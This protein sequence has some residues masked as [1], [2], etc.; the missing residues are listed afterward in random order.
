MKLRGFGLMAWVAVLGLLG[1]CAS[2]APRVAA[3]APQDAQ[4]DAA[5]QQFQQAV[6]G[7]E[8]GDAASDKAMHAALDQMRTLASHCA[9]T[10]GCDAGRILLAYDGALR[11]LANSAAVDE[12]PAGD[13]L[14]SDNGAGTATGVLTAVPQTQ[15]TV[16]LLKNGKLSDL[17]ATNGPVQASLQR[18]LT[19]LRPQLVRA[20]VDY[21]Y[22]RH[23]MWPEY[24]KA[25]LP[26]AVLFGILAKESGGRVHAVSRSGA[27]G[28]LQFMPA[29]GARFGLGSI[30]GFDQRFD[31]TL[32]ARANA[33][34]LDEQLGK[35]NDNLALVL[36]AYNGGEGRVGRLVANTPNA[37]FWDP[38]IYFALSPETREYVPMVLAAAWLF[39]HP[40]RYNLRFPRIDRAPG[41]VN[42]AT[43]ASLNELAVCL[44]DDHDALYGW[45]RTLRNL[46]PQLM[47]SDIQPL[48]TRIN[49][50][51]FLEA[52]YA[53]SCVSGKWVQLAGQLQAAQ[54]PAP[55]VQV[56]SDPPPP[57]HRKAGH[58]TV[59]R[60][61]TLS[62]I[63]RRIGSQQP[64]AFRLGLARGATVAAGG[65]QSA[66]RG[67]LYLDEEPGIALRTLWIVARK[68][69]QTA[70]SWG[71]PS[72]ARASRRGTG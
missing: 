21:E 1:G 9:Q 50:P 53:H 63:V 41:Y 66:L 59:R 15:R 42:L 43:P 55:P 39:L 5:V 68:V 19:V 35:L 20:Y 61:D 11:Q 13:E 65:M 46:N 70:R 48:G 33:Q 17:V 40:E 52:A 47:P 30:N 58:Y 60:G 71:V 23:E 54:L 62:S 56:A 16:E 67:L 18:W 36:A 7:A 57:R 49:L 31:P 28:P 72:P 38:N 25:K 27:A 34:Y 10:P 14:G 51:K 69:E 3:G 44:G 4:F 24:H 45:F 22:L 37:S 6:A 26:E 12:G 8:R 32:S 2:T 29:T 64:S